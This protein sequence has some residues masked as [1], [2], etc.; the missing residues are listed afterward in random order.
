MTIF[1]KRNKLPL[2]FITVFVL[3]CC[4]SKKSNVEEWVVEEPQQ[5]DY[6]MLFET[7]TNAHRP[8]EN[9][10]GEVILI[11]EKEFIEQIT[12]IDNPKGFQYLGQTPCIVELYADW[13]KPCIVQTGLMNEMAPDYKGKVIFYRLNID[14]AYGISRAFKVENIPVILFFKPRAN[15]S[16]TI[17]Y[18]NRKE[19]TEMIDKFLLN[20]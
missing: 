6:A 2:L 4:N 20:P 10:S 16:K 15:I 18:L 14:K 17:G 1:N 13:C 8:T 3:F 12:T 5:D 7:N 19:L 9:L 11:N